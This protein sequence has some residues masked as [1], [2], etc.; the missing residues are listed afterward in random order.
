MMKQVFVLMALLCLVFLSSQQ[1]AF[2]EPIKDFNEQIAEN[3]NILNNRKISQLNQLNQANQVNRV[4]VEKRSFI[5][6]TVANLEGD[7]NNS[8]L[9]SGCVIVFTLLEDFIKSNKSLE[10]IIDTATKICPFLDPSIRVVC[11]LMIRQM[12][13]EV[14]KAFLERENPYEVCEMIHLCEKPNSEGIPQNMDR[15][16]FEKLKDQISQAKKERQI[17]RKN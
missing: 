4:S 13:P 10:Y 8:T 15:A 17:Y 5:P 7:S 9:C 11:P 6:E 14:I 12:T 1:Q 3:T 2:I 16:S